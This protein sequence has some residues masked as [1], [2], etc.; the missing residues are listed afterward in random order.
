MWKDIFK[1]TAIAGTLDILAA[2]TKAFI[3]NKVTPGIVLKF[4]ASGIMGN[5]AFSGDYPI[6]ILGL[7]IHFFIVFCITL[8]FFLVYPKLRFLKQSIFLNSFLIAI[9]AWTI[10]TQIIIPLSKIKTPP[11][12]LLNAFMAITILYV[13]IG[14]PIAFFTRHYYRG[15]PGKSNGR[16]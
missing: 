2:F 10:T 7:I 6:M 13:C 12:N 1:T 8:T 15:L 14:L 11:F 16:K 3:S 9:I 4:I 5:E